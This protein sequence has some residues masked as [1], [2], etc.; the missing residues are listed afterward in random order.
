MK[1]H[2]SLFLKNIYIRRDSVILRLANIFSK[3]SLSTRFFYK[4][5]LTNNFLYNLSINASE[6]V[7]A[8]GIYFYLYDNFEW[9]RNNS[10]VNSSWWLQ[11]YNYF[12]ILNTLLTI[13]LLAFLRLKASPC[14]TLKVELTENLLANLL[15]LTIMIGINI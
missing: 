9:S 8:N 13:Y 1:Y 15:F 14:H 12:S 6:S 5:Y 2:L 4:H 7:T 10:F 11:C 3:F